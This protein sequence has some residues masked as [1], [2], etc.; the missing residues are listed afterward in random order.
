M[1]VEG[2]SKIIAA[3][4]EPFRIVSDALP[5]FISWW[6]ALMFSFNTPD[7]LKLTIWSVC[8]I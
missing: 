3:E 6:E 7:M 2:I 1:M 8:P 5:L 4:I